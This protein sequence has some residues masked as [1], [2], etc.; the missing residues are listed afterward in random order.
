MV[1]KF[2]K[3]NFWRFFIFGI[4]GF[5]AF[6]IDLGFFN[7]FYSIALGFLLSRVLSAIIAMVFNFI[8]NRN[9]TFSARHTPVKK[10]I[11]KWLIVYTIGIGLNTLVGKLVIVFLGES[12]LNANIAFFSGLLVS[13][14]I[15]FLGSLLWAFKKDKTPII[16]S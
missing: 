1:I 3:R 6:L 4:I 15:C 7:L 12:V 13:V 16:I 9:I 8:L 5:I 14:P 2:V 11:V 10:Q